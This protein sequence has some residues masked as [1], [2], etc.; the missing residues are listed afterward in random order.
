MRHSDQLALTLIMEKRAAGL[1]QG[2]WNM[3]GENG[4]ERGLNTF[5]LTPG[6]GFLGNLGSG[7]YNIGRGRFGRG[8]A[9]LGI[10][11]ASAFTGGAAGWL[12]KG[13]RVGMKA[14]P[15]ASKGL[16]TLNRAG[17]GVIKSTPGFQSA[18]MGSVGAGMRRTPFSGTAADVGGQ[19]F[20]NHESVSHSAMDPR[21]KMFN[22]FTGA[23]GMGASVMG[24]TQAADPRFLTPA[25]VPSPMSTMF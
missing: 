21:N 16:N 23:A 24:N 12:A 6:V 25:S 11:A 3:M 18:V 5:S 8:L 4:V 10:G 17:A 2:A 7:V 13:T 9:D 20:K 19:M 22:G 1:A 15:W 14:L